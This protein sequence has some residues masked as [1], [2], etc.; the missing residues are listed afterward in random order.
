[1]IVVSMAII[2]SRINNVPKILACLEKQT[3]RPDKVI[4]YFSE[5]PWHMDEGFS[6]PPEFR[7]SLDLEVVKVPNYGS[8]RKYLFT[9]QRFRWADVAIV[10]LDDDLIWSHNLIEMLYADLDKFGCVT[11]RGWSDFKIVSDGYEPIFQ[12]GAVIEGYSI[13]HPTEVKVASSGWATMF[14][15][16]DVDYRL[17]DTRLHQSCQ[18]GYSDEIFL[19]AMLQT[20]KYV[21]P[22]K[23]GLFQKIKSGS[24]LCRLQ[25]TAQVKAI[26]A[27][28]L[29]S[30]RIR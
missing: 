8:C 10:L 15:A 1:M 14:K 25:K 18:I 24:A 29:L 28:M 17:F 3:V 19:S 12:R 5:E 9:A 30:N 21:L 20:A 22:F 16:K 4:L 26:Q 13:D 11:T 7:T 23:K 2:R 6:D 27:G